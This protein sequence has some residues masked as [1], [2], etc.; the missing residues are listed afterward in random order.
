MD[1]DLPAAGS[2]DQRPATRFFTS[3]TGHR[4]ASSRR[5]KHAERWVAAPSAAIAGFVF[6]D[7]RD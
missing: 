7:R 4:R 3:S 6:M 2:E 1:G 5:S